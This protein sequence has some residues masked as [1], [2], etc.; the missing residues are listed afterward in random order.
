MVNSVRDF[1]VLGGLTNY[2]RIFIGKY[3]KVTLALTEIPK[4]S[5]TSQ[6]K[7]PD[8]SAKWE[9]TQ[10]AELAFRKLKMTITESTTLQHF[11]RA[12]PIIIHTDES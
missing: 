8:G 6:G 4:K 7:E 11:N 5:E 10:E 12:K 3:A 2:Y 9:S 1:L